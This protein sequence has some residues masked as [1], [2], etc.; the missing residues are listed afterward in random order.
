[1]EVKKNTLVVGWQSGPSPVLLNYSPDHHFFTASITFVSAL[2]LLTDKLMCVL[3]TVH[4]CSS[5]QVQTRV[6]HRYK[7]DYQQ[8]LTSESGDIHILQSSR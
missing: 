6:T 3:S 5:V 1:M 2:I 7:S 4:D 8:G